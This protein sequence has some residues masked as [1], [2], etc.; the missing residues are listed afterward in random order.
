MSPGFIVNIREA[1]KYY[2]ADFFVKGGGD[3]PNLLR[4][5]GQNDFPLRGAGLYP[6]S[7]KN[8]LSRF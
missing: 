4:V 8:P 5:F 2:L 6:L 1:V 3:P 7:G